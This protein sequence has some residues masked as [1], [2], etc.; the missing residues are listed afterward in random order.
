MPRCAAG[1]LRF[2]RNADS[3]GARFMS[4]DAVRDPIKPLKN[5]KAIVTG[6][7]SGIGEGCA[8]ALGAAGAAVA[9]NY[10][11][12]KDDAERIAQ[13]INDA[14]GE[15]FPIHADVSREDQVQ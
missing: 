14:G 12:E 2:P 8:I 10:R 9:V 5:Q 11:S 4:P 15:A 1:R 7:S 3:F 6:A 13:Q